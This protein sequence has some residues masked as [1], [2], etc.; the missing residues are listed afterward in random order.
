[1]SQNPQ[2]PPVTQQAPAVPPQRTSTRTSTSGEPAPAG[3]NAD[4]PTAGVPR[5]STPPTIRPAAGPVPPA[6]SR[7]GQTSFVEQGQLGRPGQRSGDFHS[8]RPAT[9]PTAAPAGG[10]ASSSSVPGPRRVRLTLSHMDPWSVMKLAFLLSI[11]IGIMIVVAA[12]LS[13][14]VLNQMGVFAKINNLVINDLQATSFGPILEYMEFSRVLS[15]AT[16]IAVIDIVLFTALATLG[17]F[18]YNF[19]AAMVGGLHLT[20]TDD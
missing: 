12:A 1:M 4:A 2:Q 6:A 17:A 3:V 9:A 16:V 8:T 13:W 20:L 10:A 7:A 19:V 18:I 14:M 5:T 15:V 11:A